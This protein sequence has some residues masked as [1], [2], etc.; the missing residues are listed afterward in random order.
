MD[1]EVP[2]L[3][4]TPEHGPTDVR[5]TDASSNRVVWLPSAETQPSGTF[6]A[7]LYDLV[8]LQLGFAVSD[9][10]ELSIAGVPPVDN[11]PY[12]YEL[13]VKANVLRASVL[14]L[15]LFGSLGVFVS[16]E[17][18][19]A[20]GGRVGGTSQLCLT[21]TCGSYATFSLGLL[22]T[23][24]I[25][26]ALPLALGVGVVVRLHRLVALVV[27]SIYG[28]VQQTFSREIFVLNYT[29]RIGTASWSLDVGLTRPFVDEIAHTP[30]VAGLPWLAFTYRFGFEP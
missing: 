3:P 16:D 10:V 15:A 23:D 13:S 20:F 25:D 21:E 4:R 1:D 9:R 5:Y 14:R 18:D 29:A 12:M 2:G 26:R 7:A 30:L 24:R 17:R 28:R 8:G 6:F 22:V 27:E 11:F 19:V